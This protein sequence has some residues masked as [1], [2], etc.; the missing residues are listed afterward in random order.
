VVGPRRAASYG[1]TGG[2]RRVGIGGAGGTGTCVG[3]RASDGRRNSVGMIVLG[4]ALTWLS[5]VGQTI[6]R[7]TK[8]PE[9]KIVYGTDILNEAWRPGR[10]ALSACLRSVGDEAFYHQLSPSMGGS[11]G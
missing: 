1:G 10:V 3:R 4:N 9:E 6:S 5:V 7:E 8:R 2:R 11:P